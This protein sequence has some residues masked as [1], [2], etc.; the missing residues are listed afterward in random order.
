MTSERW[1]IDDGL[2]YRSR[3]G[4]DQLTEIKLGDLST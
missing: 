1:V 4:Q 2:E 3:I